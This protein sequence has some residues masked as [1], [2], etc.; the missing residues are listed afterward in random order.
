M[1][2]FFR[3]GKHE[4]VFMNPDKISHSPDHPNHLYQNYI[5]D[6]LIPGIKDELDIRYPWYTDIDKLILETNPRIVEYDE[7]QLDHREE[8]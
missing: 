7:S 8:D 2:L 1:D 6:I 5:I 3:T 4:F